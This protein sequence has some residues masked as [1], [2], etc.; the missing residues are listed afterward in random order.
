VYGQQQ[1]F[2]GLQGSSHVVW[3]VTGQPV[4]SS[5]LDDKCAHMAFPSETGGTLVLER[6][7]SKLKAYR[8]DAQGAPGRAAEL[9]EAATA[10]GIIDAQNRA[11]VAVSQSGVYAARWYDQD[12]KP[13]AA[14]F[15]LP[16]R[17]GSTPMVRPLAGGGAAVQIDGDWVAISRSGAASA[18]APPPW[19]SSH[20]NFDLQIIRQGRAYAF[21]PRAGASPH[22]TLDLFSGAGE[23]CGAV[24]LPTDGLSM[25]PDGTVIGSSGEGGCTHP[26]WSGLLR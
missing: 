3:S 23:R 20:K 24:K 22:D 15:A 2:Q 10:A 19:L 4:R 18:E 6:C 11:F 1:G 25:G 8:F 5:R 14:P 9:G 16:G 7:G 13:A 12:L 17:G 21:I 26:I